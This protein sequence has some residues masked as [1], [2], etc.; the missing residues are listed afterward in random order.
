MVTNVARKRRGAN[1]FT[2]ATVTASA[3]DIPMPAMKRVMTNA[4]SD[5]QY[6]ETTPK[7]P[8]ISTAAIMELR[9]PYPITERPEKEGTDEARD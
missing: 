8:I 3:P 4:T 5:V 6:P 1:S 7:M 9:P 2:A